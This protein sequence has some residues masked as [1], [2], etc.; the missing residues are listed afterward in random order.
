MPSVLLSV[1][2]LAANKAI[3]SSGRKQITLR[4]SEAT[5]EK[6]GRLAPTRIEQA[7]LVDYLVR[8]MKPDAKWST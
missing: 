6:L 1:D 5:V 4:L 2:F 3:A 8:R 7:A